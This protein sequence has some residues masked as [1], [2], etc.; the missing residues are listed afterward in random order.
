MI[1]TAEL[2]AG[3]RERPVGLCPRCHA[4]VRAFDRIGKKCTKPLPFGAKCAGVIRSAIAADEWTECTV[5]GARGRI[6][7]SVCTGCDGDGWLYHR[8]RV[9]VTG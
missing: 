2:S 9:P 7:D 5:C 3:K 6:D 8:R 4:V 1:A